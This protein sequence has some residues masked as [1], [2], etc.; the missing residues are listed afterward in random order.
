MA[1]K[2]SSRQKPWAFMSWSAVTAAFASAAAPPAIPATGAVDA[3]VCH[4][5]ILLLCMEA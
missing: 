5:E 3:I 4:G 1:S 2:Y